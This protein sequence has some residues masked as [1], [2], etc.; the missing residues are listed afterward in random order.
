MNRGP[1]PTGPFSMRYS[2]FPRR[3]TSTESARDGPEREDIPV[4]FHS[5]SFIMLY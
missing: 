4:A 2:H 1:H 5:M 3:Q